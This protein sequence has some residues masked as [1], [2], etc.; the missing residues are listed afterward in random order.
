VL[1][2]SEIPSGIC[3]KLR[4]VAESNNRDHV[5]QSLYYCLFVPHICIL[6]FLAHIPFVANHTIN[7][8]P[9]E[10]LQQCTFE[11]SE[12]KHF[13]IKLSRVMMTSEHKCLKRSLIRHENTSLWFLKWI[14]KLSLYNIRPVFISLHT[15]EVMQTNPLLV[16]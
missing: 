1:L 4:T 13:C 2:R 5:P 6:L 12:Q 9:R 7:A 11:I 3:A 15:S 8:T 14:F 10:R 16:V